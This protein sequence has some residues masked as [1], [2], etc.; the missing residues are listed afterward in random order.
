[1]SDATTIR[2]GDERADILSLRSV[3][4]RYRP[5]CRHRAVSRQVDARIQYSSRVK[6][7]R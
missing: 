5:W 1:M 6:D 3:R 4:G 2:R 7:P